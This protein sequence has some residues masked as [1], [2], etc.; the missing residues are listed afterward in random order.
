[1]LALIQQADGGTISRLQIRHSTG[2]QYT[3]AAMLLGSVAASLWWQD[4]AILMLPLPVVLL[5][6]PLLAR[7][8]A[9]DGGM[10]LE[11]G[12]VRLGENFMPYERIGYARLGGP[13]AGDFVHFHGVD[14]ALLRKVPLKPA[15]RGLAD[16]Y[17]QRHL[18]FVG[19]LNRRVRA[20]G[21]PG[22][23]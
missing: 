16:V 12:G 1:M 17:D 20:A 13:A 9:P 6:W 4:P 11:A 22:I 10:A 5:A 19:E 7:F 14:G 18:D 21:N 2:F 3:G 15:A 8:L 23:C